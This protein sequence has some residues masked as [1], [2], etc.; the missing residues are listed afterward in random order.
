MD[1]LARAHPSVYSGTPGP[2]LGDQ[3]EGI[4]DDYYDSLR[5]MIQIRTDLL[6]SACYRA[7][8]SACVTRCPAVRMRKAAPP[9]LVHSPARTSS[10]VH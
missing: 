2:P 10:Q 9:T 1:S 8:L 5:V 3:E 7:W 6:T 4:D